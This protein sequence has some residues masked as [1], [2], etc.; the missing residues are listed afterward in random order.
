MS[1]KLKMDEIAALTGYSV[2]TVSRVLSGKSYTSDNARDAIVSCARRLG[3]LDS[4]SS[5][6]LLINGIAIFAPLL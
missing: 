5:G 4:L 6:R 3:V 1:G 2:S